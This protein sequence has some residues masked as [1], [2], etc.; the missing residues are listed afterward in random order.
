VEFEDLF[1]SSI[2][3]KISEKSF[4]AYKGGTP[5]APA[6]Q[7]GTT[8]IGDREVS[9]NRKVG[10]NIEVTY[11]PTSQEA[12]AMDYLQNQL[13]S[14]YQGAMQPQD[15]NKQAEAYRQN[16]LDDLSRTYK[17]GLGDATSQLVSS[18]LS[19]SSQGLDQLRAFNEPYMQQ[20]ASINANAPLMAQQL[21]AGQ[22]DIGTSQLTNAI[23]ALNQYYNTGQT[24]QG[25]ANTASNIGNNWAQTNY[26]NQMAAK[27]MADQNRLAYTKLALQTAGTGA[28]L[29]SDI[30]TKRNINKVDTRNGINIYEFEYK[31]DKYPELPKGKQVGVI[32]QEVEHIKNA[33][34]Q[35]EK[36]KLVD[37][38]VIAPLIA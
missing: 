19:S 33:V 22:Q 5:E 3:N 29:A 2:L 31:T 27:Q 21:Q 7:G 38:A 34:V 12:Q 25:G 37:Y 28:Q 18:G 23:N 16:Q 24:F 35:G 15:F 11:N 4:R 30:C 26:Q 20:Q 32:A 1:G 17:R 14:L 10:N 6:Y 9:T 36:Y 8:K 13:P